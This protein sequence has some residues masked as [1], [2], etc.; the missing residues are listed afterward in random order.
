MIVG[1]VF[2]GVGVVA[3]AVIAALIRGYWSTAGELFLLFIIVFAIRFL[4][5]YLAAKAD[6]V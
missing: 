1:L 3:I 4:A 6:D 5:F 2:A